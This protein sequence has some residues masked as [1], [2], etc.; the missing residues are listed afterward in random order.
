MPEVIANAVPDYTQF[1]R[2]TKLRLNPNKVEDLQWRIPGE[3]ATPETQVSEVSDNTVQANPPIS[4]QRMCPLLN[5]LQ[6]III[7][8]EWMEIDHSLELDPHIPYQ[9]WHQV[10]MTS[11]LTL[12]LS[13]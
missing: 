3:F 12:E 1:G 11:I 10:C 2:V 6:S 5:H 13:Q 4:H 8:Q 7:S 9:L